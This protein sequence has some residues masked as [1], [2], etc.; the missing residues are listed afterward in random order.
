MSAGMVL[1]LVAALTAARAPAGNARVVNRPLNRFG[2]FRLSLWACLGAIVPMAVSCSQSPALPSDA[3]LRA[4]FPARKAALE[5][6]AAWLQ[7][8]GLTS[9]QLL[10]LGQASDRAAAEAGLS[11]ARLADYAGQ[12]KAAGAVRIAQDDAQPGMAGA[13]VFYCGRYEISRAGANKGYAYLPA[14]PS[15]DPDN[16]VIQSE[17]LDGFDLATRYTAYSPLEGNWYLYYTGGD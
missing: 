4:A 10:Q 13:L 7:D 8:D 1:G 5:Q 16:H 15:L 12:M 2:R 11:A 14:P 3:E 17:T 6:L 9:G